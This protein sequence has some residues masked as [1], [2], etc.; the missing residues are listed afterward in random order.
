MENTFYDLK[1]LFQQSGC[2]IC[3]LKSSFEE[4]YLDTLL[5]ENV[6]DPKVRERIRSQNGFCQEHIQL[7]FQSR[8]SVLGISIIYDDLLR[9]HLQTDEKE[10]KETV[11]PLCLAWKEKNRYIHTT[12]VKHWNDLKATYNTRLFF[13]P[14]HIKQYETDKI[15]YQDMNKLTKE[16]LKKIGADLSSFI[17]KYDYRAKKDSI[18]IN[19]IN[20]WQEVLEY[21]ASRRLRNNRTHRP[22]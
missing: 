3:A 21:F 12:L 19:E 11:C 7:I 8:P 20:S 16:N 10:S 15:I 2:P 1:E 17:K 14:T 9:H 5:Y 18:T 13:C 4:R 6:N 22:A